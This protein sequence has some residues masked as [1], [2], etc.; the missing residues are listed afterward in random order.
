MRL[1]R[2]RYD[3]ILQADSQAWGNAGLF[4]Y[5]HFLVQFL[6]GAQELAQRMTDHLEQNVPTRC[7]ECGA[8][9]KDRLCN[10][11]YVDDKF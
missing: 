1:S 7:I 11:C 9:S 8:P 10:R 5:R 6:I 3:A 4:Q 2:A